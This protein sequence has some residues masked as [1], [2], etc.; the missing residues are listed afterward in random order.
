MLPEK[1][2]SILKTD[3]ARAV[4]RLVPATG[5]AETGRWLCPLGCKWWSTHPDCRGCASP[6]HHDCVD[7]ARYNLSQKSA[8]E[9]RSLLAF[10]DWQLEVVDKGSHANDEILHVEG[11]GRRANFL[12]QQTGELGGP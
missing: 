7:Q 2:T 12:G 4:V 6:S 1:L 5:Y 8:V 3:P 9:T 10:V 11:L